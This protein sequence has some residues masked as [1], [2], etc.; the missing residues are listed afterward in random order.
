VATTFTLNKKERLK[1][2]K[3]IESLFRDGNSFSVFPVK[4]F[5]RFEK[6]DAGSAAINK[7]SS[8]QFG[9]GAGARN[10]KKAPD[11]NRIKRLGREA[12]RLQKADLQLRLT[13]T[14]RSLSLF[15]IFIGK[16]LPTFELMK[17]KTRVI[18]ERLIKLTDENR[19]ANS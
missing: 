12:Y 14:D 16:E 7:S 3:Q 9:I 18:L 10:F 8:L 11:R 2:R 5:Y 13:E 6:K 19:A 15:F 4:V 1:S 17:E